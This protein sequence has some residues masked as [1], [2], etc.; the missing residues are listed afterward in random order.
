MFIGTKK[1][2]FCKIYC[3]QFVKFFIQS[4]PTSLCIYIYRENNEHQPRLAM[5]VWARNFRSFRRI[6]LQ[7]FSRQMELSA[8]SGQ[9]LD[10]RCSQT[11]LRTPETGTHLEKMPRY[12]F[13]P[14]MYPRERRKPDFTFGNRKMERRETNVSSNAWNEMRINRRREFFILRELSKKFESCM[15][16]DSSFGRKDTNRI[17]VD[18]FCKVRIH[19]KEY[20]IFVKFTITTTLPHKFE[21]L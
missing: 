20:F 15:G 3:N 16:M 21:F 17:F 19:Y 9:F 5:K 13:I 7:T 8:A 10:L 4:V 6:E 14:L 12:L 18:S 2:F 11:W 1:G